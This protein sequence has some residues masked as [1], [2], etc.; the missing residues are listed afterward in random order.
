MDLTIFLSV[1][2]KYKLLDAKIES[3]NVWIY[4]RFRIAWAFAKQINNFGGTH[5][6][7]NKTELS[8]LR[9]YFRMLINI[10]KKGR[11]KKECVDVLILNHPRRILT[12]GI[13]E[14]IYTDKIA[15]LIANSLVLEGP[16]QKL[17]YQPVNTRNLLYTDMV[18]IK[19]FLHCVYVKNFRPKRFRSIKDSIRNLLELPILELNNML[20]TKV[21][22]SVLVDEITYGFFMYE[23]ENEYYKNVLKWTHPKLVLEMVSYSR[24]SMII[25]EWSKKM[26]IPTIELQHGVMGSEHAAYNYSD[27]HRIMQFPDYIFLFSD[28]WKKRARFPI[29]DSNIRSVGFPYLER[30]V[31]KYADNHHIESDVTNILFLSSGPMGEELSKIAYDLKLLLDKE[32]YHIIFKLHPGEYAIWKYKYPLLMKGNIEVIDNNNINLY[33]IFSRSDLQVC[34]FGTTAILEGLS[35]GLPAYVIKHNQ[36]KEFIDLSTAGFAELFEDAKDLAER[37]KKRDYKGD[38]TDMKEAF[39][40][41]HALQNIKKEIIQIAGENEIH[42]ND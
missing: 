16:Y 35:F 18:D 38:S 27:S 33:E 36:I 6:E 41:K 17:H 4:S 29:P 13:Y 26:N 5:S 30:M 2:K 25:N 11:L 24:S 15:D 39:W 1:E 32:N 23:I 19:S 37:I 10:L 7:G 42:W 3:Y 22:L 14:C 20:G 9:L 40:K 12:D 28:Y 8:K 34:G 31:E 21:N